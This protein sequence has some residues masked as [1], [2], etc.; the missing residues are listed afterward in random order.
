M[1]L[2]LTPKTWTNHSFLSFFFSFIGAF[3]AQ[4]LTSFFLHTQ[5][6]LHKTTFTI[7]LSSNT[8]IIHQCLLQGIHFTLHIHHPP[9]IIIRVQNP[10]P[11]YYYYNNNAH[12]DNLLSVPISNSPTYMAS[13]PSFMALSFNDFKHRMASS[14]SSTGSLPF[15]PGTMHCRMLRTS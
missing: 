12:K 11:D 14:R 3:S 2:S 10:Y 1:L 7:S 13:S 4:Y 15:P 5:N 6:A 8:L 9:S